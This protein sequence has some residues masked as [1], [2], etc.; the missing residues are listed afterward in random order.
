MKKIKD[1]IVL[2][3]ISGLAVMVPVLIV[4]TLM[5]R[6]GKTDVPYGLSAA[7][8]FLTDKAAQTPGGKMLSFLVNSVNV[9]MTSTTLTYVLSLTGKE[10]ALFK[11]AGVGTIF[12][13]GIAGLLSSTGLNIKSKRPGTPII[14]FL[15]HSIGGAANAY[16]ITKLGDDSLFP[17]K[18]VRAQEKIPVVYTGKQSR[19]RV[20][21]RSKKIKPKNERT[22][23]VNEATIH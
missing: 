22:S 14:S 5:H 2:G 7:K 13:L 20:M 21:A 4:N 3:A 16:L 8:L 17:D 1:R 11:G 6:K 9:S 12:W 18:E 19:Q 10:Y 23:E 15:E